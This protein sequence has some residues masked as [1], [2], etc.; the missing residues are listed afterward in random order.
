[1]HARIRQDCFILPAPPNF[2]ISLQVRHSP[3]SSRWQF[4]HCPHRVRRRLI[5]GPTFVP[6][7]GPLGPVFLGVDFFCEGKKRKKTGFF[8]FWKSNSQVLTTLLLGLTAVALVQSLRLLSS[9]CCPCLW[10]VLAE[11]TVRSPCFSTQKSA[12]ETAS[13]AR[14][15]GGGGGER[16]SRSLILVL[17]PSVSLSPSL[18]WRPVLLQFFPVS[19]DRRK[20]RVNSG[21]CQKQGT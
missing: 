11:W 18:R 12:R 5:P 20:L 6:S 7:I 19:N 8:P 3:Q 14:E 13:E 10:L 16:K 9:E 17:T 2:F 4:S 21:L 1:M 15:G